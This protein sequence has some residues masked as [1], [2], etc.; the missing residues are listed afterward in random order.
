M[1]PLLNH[2]DTEAD[3]GSVFLGDTGD[4][5]ITLVDVGHITSRN[6]QNSQGILEPEL[7]DVVGP[8]VADYVLPTL[9][10]LRHAFPLER[11]SA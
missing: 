11:D 4:T 3:D 5:C 6:R 9:V 10:S 7:A 1:K 2:K 8:G